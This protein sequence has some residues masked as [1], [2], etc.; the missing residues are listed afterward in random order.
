[1]ANEI[2]PIEFA[3]TVEKVQTIVSGGIRVWLE[4]PAGSIMEAAQLMECM[5]PGIIL[6]ISAKPEDGKKHAQNKALGRSKATKRDS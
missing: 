2:P 5:R 6:E 4:L 1:M 3:A